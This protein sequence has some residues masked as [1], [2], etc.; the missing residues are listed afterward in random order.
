M[1]VIWFAIGL[2]IGIVATIIFM[3][4]HIERRHV[5][6]LQVYNDPTDNSE[7]LFCDLNQGLSFIKQQKQVIFTVEDKTRE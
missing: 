1:W 2:V 6:K 5:G 3:L 4:L 7:Y